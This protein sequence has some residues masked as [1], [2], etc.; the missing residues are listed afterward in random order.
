VSWFVLIP[1][2]ETAWSAADRVVS[3]TPLPLTDAGRE[4]ARTWADRLASL[5]LSVIYS[6]DERTSVETARIVADRRRA[7]HRTMIQLAEVDAGL[8]EGLTSDELKRRYPK[9][10]KR[11][12]DDPS[13]V[14]PPEGEDLGDAHA[15]LRQTLE[16]IF[17]KHAGQSTAVVL[18]PLA[19]GLTRSLIES[20]EPARARLLTC[21]EPLGY[22]LAGGVAAL[23][24]G[25]SAIE[26][27]SSAELEAVESQ[28]AAVCRGS[29]RAG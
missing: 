22:R 24:T 28:G 15:R 6:S 5:G 26:I 18:G 29:D 27:S 23:P 13:S 11:W 9:V 2:P 16:R 14:C 25:L 17:R 12:C 3:R 20:A 7:R 1:W 10:F 8:W 19:L 4:Q 21:R